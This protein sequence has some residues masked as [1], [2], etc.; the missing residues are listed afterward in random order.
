[1]QDVSQSSAVRHL[2]AWRVWL[3]T[4]VYPPDCGGSGWSTHA[5]ARVLSDNGHAV[6]IIVV[7]PSG[8][9]VTRRAYEETT[10][11]E[12]GV[13]ASRTLSNRLGANDYA[14]A[15]LSTYLDRRLQ[16]ESDVDIVHAQHL[17]S[18]PPA[19]A[20]GRARARA[21]IATVRDYW[22]VCLHGTSWWGS[23][24]CDGCTTANLTGCMAEYWRWPAPV[25]RVMVGWGRR[26]QQ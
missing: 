11:T 17:L 26:S 18:G 23:Q 25:A 8:T 6:E 15:A 24:N 20:A 5:L 9:E 16:V 2:Q 4:D 19:I 10:V 1:M 3:V 22:P 7:D 13:R 21:T 12:V 14:H